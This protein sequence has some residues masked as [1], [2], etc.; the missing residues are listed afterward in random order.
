MPP[1]LPGDTLP[2]P[3]GPAAEAQRATVR[4]VGNYLREFQYQ[5]E[6]GRVPD[7]DDAADLLRE[8]RKARSAI[9]RYLAALPR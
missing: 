1:N 3:A 5:A 4:E 6:S 9:Q 2:G 7:G 8:T